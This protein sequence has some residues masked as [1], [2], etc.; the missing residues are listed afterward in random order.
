[1]NEKN[2]KAPEEWVYRHAE[3][4]I[5]VALGASEH[6]PLSARTALLRAIARRALS[7]LP[8]A[9]FEARELAKAIEVESMSRRSPFR[10]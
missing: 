10:D 9:T 6:L 2:D 7:H 1:M 5:A 4:L 3:R 8:N